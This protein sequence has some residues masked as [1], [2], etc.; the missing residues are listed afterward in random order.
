[1]NSIAFIDFEIEPNSRKTLDIGSINGNGDSFH[2][3][4]IAV[5]IKYSLS[6]KKIRARKRL[7]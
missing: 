6:N 1:M 2:S 5:L 3:S 4:T 7:R